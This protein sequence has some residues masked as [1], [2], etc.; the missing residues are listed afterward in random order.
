MEN[1]TTNTLAQMEIKNLTEAFLEGPAKSVRRLCFFRDSI[2][3]PSITICHMVKRY[4]QSNNS[5]KMSGEPVYRMQAIKR[6]LRNR[7]K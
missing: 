7:K 6:S 5:R 2:F 3:L 1:I 4:S